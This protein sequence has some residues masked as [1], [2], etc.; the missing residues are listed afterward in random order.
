VAE[1][2]ATGERSIDERVRAALDRSV[3][4]G[5]PGVLETAVDAR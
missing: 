3:Q 4:L 1:L 2:P 5:Y